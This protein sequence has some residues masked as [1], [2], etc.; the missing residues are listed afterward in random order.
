MKRLTI[1]F[2]LPLFIS[3]FFLFFGPI[4]SVN[5][6]ACVSP[7]NHNCLNGCT[8]IGQCGPNNKVCILI[9]PNTVAPNGADCGSAIIG[10]ITAPQGVGVYNCDTGNCTNIGIFSFISVALRLF[11]VICG[12]FMFFNFLWAGYALITKAGDTKAF[13]DVRERLQYAMIGLVIIVA[14]YMLAAIIGL[15]FFGNAGFILKPDI[16]QYG[17]TAP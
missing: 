15:V 2:I 3:F 16:S 13:T 11:T 10:G 8:S 4:S 12:L 1:L 9:G 6:V 14:A 17:A 5:A 7:P